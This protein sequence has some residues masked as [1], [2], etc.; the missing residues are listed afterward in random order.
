[1]LCHAARTVNDHRA[2]ASW[3]TPLSPSRTSGRSSVLGFL[4]A[5]FF[6]LGVGAM[7]SLVPRLVPEDRS[8]RPAVVLEQ[9]LELNF[10]AVAGPALAGICASSLDG[11]RRPISI[12]VVAFV[13]RIASIAQLPRILP[14]ARCRPAEPALDP[15]RLPL[16][17]QPAG[18]PRILPRRPERDG[19]RDAD[20][21]LPGDRDPSLRRPALTGYLYAAPYA[22]ALVSSLLPGGSAH[23][24]RQGLAVV[25]AASVGAWRSPR[26][27]SRIALAP[28]CCSLSRARPTTM[29]AIFRLDHAHRDRRTRCA[30]GWS[31]SSS[32]RSRA[33]DAR[34]HRGR[35]GRVVH[36]PPLLD[37]VR[38]RAV[39]AARS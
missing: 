25:L 12:D 16:R 31:G 4:A 5:S 37:R 32:P 26:S 6:C 34:Q 35:P 11:L 20:G 28:L 2:P 30:G 13:A 15:R 9:H 23:V 27:A 14:S 21:A 38:G 22:G 33:P 10:V 1:M 8:P 7:R 36:E 3:R 24:R 29:S 17:P 39:R 19:L 18:G